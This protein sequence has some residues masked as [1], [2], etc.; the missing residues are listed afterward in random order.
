MMEFNMRERHTV[1]DPELGEGETLPQSSV[2]VSL[3]EQPWCVH[4]VFA[5]EVLCD[6]LFISYTPT[7]EELSSPCS[8]E[9]YLQHRHR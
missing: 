2:L 1:V 5:S 3:G 4:K 8:R 7:L 6:F 9:R